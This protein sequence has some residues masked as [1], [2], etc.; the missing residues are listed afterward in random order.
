[1]VDNTDNQSKTGRVSGFEDPTT[2]TCSTTVLLDFYS[3][4]VEPLNF[5][6]NN[7]YQEI[8]RSIPQLQLEHFPQEG[9]C[10]FDPKEE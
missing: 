8:S 6:P 5:P 10:N 9:N 3:S 1:M 4:K 7:I 2:I